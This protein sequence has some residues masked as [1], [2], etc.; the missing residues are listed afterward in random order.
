MKDRVRVWLLLLLLWFPNLAHASE[1]GHIMDTWFN[2]IGIVIKIIF[3]FLVV[4]G[5][6]YLLVKKK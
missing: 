1:V 6:I 2:I 3:C 4:I 5:V